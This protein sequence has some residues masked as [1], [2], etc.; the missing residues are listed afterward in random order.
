MLTR[1]ALSLCCLWLLNACAFKQHQI[2]D[3]ADDLE[4]FG[5]QQSL[6]NLDKIEPQTADNALYLLNRGSLKYLAGDFEGSIKDLEAAKQLMASLQAISL[7]ENLGAFTVNETLRAYAGSPSELVIVHQWLA[8]NYL[9]LGNLDAARV[10][11]LQADVTMKALAG[12]D[13]LQGQLA[14]VHFLTGLIYECNHEYDN[15]LISYRFAAEIMQRRH[16]PLPSALIDS[17]LQLS[18]RLDL[19]TEYQGYVKRFGR[20]VSDNYRQQKQLVVFASRGL[21]SRKKQ[22]LMPVFSVQHQVYLSLAL[23]YYPPRQQGSDVSQQNIPSLAYPTQLIEDYDY[24][25][26]QDLA[27]LMPK[28]TAT[29][30]LRAATKYQAVKNAQNNGNGMAAVLMNIATL[31]TEQADLRSWNIL[32]ANLQVARLSV[33]DQALANV[34]DTVARQGGELKYFDRDHIV[35]LLPYRSH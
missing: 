2:G 33:D 12:K 6:T 25:Q 27:A 17:L 35:L 29:S 3:I 21:V 14:S 9:Q 5:V 4:R 19:K 26:R 24:L 11:M 30:L 28:L 22:Q 15:A 20:T 13:T 23:P 18:D 16:Q 32:P 10:E 34:V 1:L 8:F 31:V 7:T